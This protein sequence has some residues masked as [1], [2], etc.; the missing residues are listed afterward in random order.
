MSQ[1]TMYVRAD[2]NTGISGSI[3]LF[4]DARRKIKILSIV[5]EV[6]FPLNVTNVRKKG[7]ESADGFEQIN[8]DL[9]GSL[10]TGV[11][12]P[13]QGV[14]VVNT[15]CKEMK[16]IRVPVV[17][18]KPASEQIKIQPD[19]VRFGVLDRKHEHAKTSLIVRL[20]R[21]EA[22]ELEHV[23]SSSALMTLDTR[24]LSKK[25]NTWILDCYLI[26]KSKGKVEEMV[27]ISVKTPA[28][29]IEKYLVPVTAYIKS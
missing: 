4:L 14:L 25:N 29:R 10:G 21:N 16:S 8:I 27:T 9:E 6:E 2:A 26:V 13:S 12:L 28:G 20:P 17:L 22:Y 19:S 23:E 7:W 18:L 5:P 3:E 1:L 24:L 15:N 11:A